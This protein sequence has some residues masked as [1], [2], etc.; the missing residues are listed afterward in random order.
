MKYIGMVLIS[1][2]LFGASTPLGK[3]LLD[4]LPPFQLAGLLYL[5]A[6]MGVF[7][8]A[9]EKKNRISLC[10]MGQKNLLRL[11]GAI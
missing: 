9:L 6:A 8:F 7:P 2:L 5:G 11:T 10:S 4:S 1:A 3:I